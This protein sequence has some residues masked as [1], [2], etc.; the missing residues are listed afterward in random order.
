[1]QQ[2]DGGGVL[3]FI[4]AGL[5]RLSNAKDTNHIA[6]PRAHVFLFQ[7]ALSFRMV[8]TNQFYNRQS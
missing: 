7:K 1:M 8:T 2:I 4:A 3:E 5:Q 6:N